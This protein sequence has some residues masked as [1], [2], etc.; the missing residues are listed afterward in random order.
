MAVAKEPAY[1]EFGRAILL[2]V[3][4][5]FPRVDEAVATAKQCRQ[6]VAQNRTEL[7]GSRTPRLANAPAEA[8][9]GRW[10]ATSAEG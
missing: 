1:L 5:G 4:A 2:H 10:R 9:S 6:F 3:Q 7:F 8:L